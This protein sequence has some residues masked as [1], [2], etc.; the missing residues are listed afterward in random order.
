MLSRLCFHSYV[1]KRADD[2]PV[3]P[4][5]IKSYNVS[6]S[7]INYVQF[8]VNIILLKKSLVKSKNV[9]DLAL[10]VFTACVN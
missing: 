4:D 5:E 7:N 6:V 2:F 3:E 9:V 8:N 1:S 10:F